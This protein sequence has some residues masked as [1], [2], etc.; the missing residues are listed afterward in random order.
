MNTSTISLKPA[1]LATALVSV[2][3][4]TG[5]KLVSSA[6]L[7][8]IRNE[9]TVEAIDVTA[10]LNDQILPWAT[11]HAHAIDDVVAAIEQQGYDAACSE[12]GTQASQAFPCTFWVEASGVVASVDTSSRVGKI[13]F[14]TDGGTQVEVLTG[15]VVPGTAVRDGYPELKY[16]DVGNQNDFATLSDDLNSEV[17]ALVNA[18]GEFKVEEPIHV[19]GAYASW[20]GGERTLQITPVTLER[21]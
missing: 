9:G 19:I 3:A 21:R 17:L 20:A 16:S 13:G 10:L 11:D 6:E 14:S 7:E 15:P 12:Y 2:L 18:A 8:A 1:L 5:F 4:T